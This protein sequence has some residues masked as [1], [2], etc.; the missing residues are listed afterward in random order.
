MRR[1][2]GYKHLVPPGPKQCSSNALLPHYEA[3]AKLANRPAANL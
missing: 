2:G 3:R 1:G